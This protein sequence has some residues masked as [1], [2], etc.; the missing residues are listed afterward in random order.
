MTPRRS[1]RTSK[2]GCTG[3]RRWT[4]C[5]CR[6]GVGCDSRAPGWRAGRCRR[7]VEIVDAADLTLFGSGAE[8]SSSRRTRRSEWRRCQ[9]LIEWQRASSSP[10]ARWSRSRRSLPWPRRRVGTSTRQSW[11]RPFRPDPLETDRRSAAEP[12]RQEAARRGRV[13]A[14]SASRRRG[15]QA[16]FRCQIPFYR[17]RWLPAEAIQELSG[18]Q[19]R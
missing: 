14:R 3:S 7:Y 19:V 9:E 18:F 15:A 2:A 17:V 11:G 12:R 10:T 6:W 16:P 1:I 5:A 13:C 4:C 8:T